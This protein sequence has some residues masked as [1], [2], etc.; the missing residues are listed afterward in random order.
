MLFEGHPE[1]VKVTSLSEKLKDI[2]VT[3]NP[4]SDS[5]RIWFD[6]VKSDVGQT[7]NEK[8][9]FSHNIGAKKTVLTAFLYFTGITRRMQWTLRVTM[10]ALHYLPKQILK[11]YQ[12]ISLIKLI[13]QN[14]N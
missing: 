5:V 12:A 3:H 10:V 1:D 2:K 7:A 13:R 6:A 11:W 4:K 9:M 8:L 14:G